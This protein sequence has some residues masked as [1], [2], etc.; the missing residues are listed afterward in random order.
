MENPNDPQEVPLLILCHI[1]QVGVDLADCGAGLFRNCLIVSEKSRDRNPHSTRNLRHC[2]YGGI[3]QGPFNLPQVSRTDTGL[4]R[5]F[6]L[7]K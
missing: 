5:Q 7:R 1:H 2:V 3:L 4:K 6:L